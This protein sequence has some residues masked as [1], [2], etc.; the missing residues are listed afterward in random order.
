[1]LASSLVVVPL[2]LATCHLG[3]LLNE[4]SH[5]ESGLLPPGGEGLVFVTQPGNVA[6][7]APIQPPVRVAVRTAAGTVDENFDGAIS[8]TLAQNP[9]GARLSG[10]TSREPDDGIATFDDLMIDAP[11]ADYRLEAAA[12]G[13]PTAA[14][15]SFSILAGPPAGVYRVDG[16]GQVDTVFATLRRPYIARVVDDDGNPLAGVTVRWEASDGG[17][18]EPDVSSTA[19]DGTASATHTLS[20]VIGEQRVTASVDGVD[21]DARFSAFARAGAAAR[22]VFT[23]QPSN[24]ERNRRISPAVRVLVEDRHG[25]PVRNFATTITIAITPGTGTRGARLSGD[26][27]RT[28]ADGEA[29]FADLRVSRTGSGYRLRAT[30]LSLTVDSSPFTVVDD[31]DDDD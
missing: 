16:D 21:D 11:G 3:Q 7:K 27:T 20:G 6:A 13:L 25:N 4:P 2:S 24:V 19:E 23:G 8:I 28:P 30:T 31:D 10:T 29:R 1:V 12:E 18:V 17:A 9:A 5:S 26:R 15:A 22:L 14:S